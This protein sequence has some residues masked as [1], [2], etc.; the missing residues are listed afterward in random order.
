MNFL[1]IKFFKYSLVL[2]LIDLLVIWLWTINSDLGP[3]SA[4][5]VYIVVPFVFIINMII[6]A[7]LFFTK[8][9]YSPLFFINCIVASAITFSLFTL[10]MNNQDKEHFDSW[11]FSLQDTTFSITKWNKYNEFS[12]SYGENTGSSTSF[13]DGKCEQKKDT[14]FLITDSIRMYIHHDKLHNFRRSKNPITLK[15]RN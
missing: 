4:M 6:G 3:G 2:A 12:I 11:D 10:E 9:V 7:I 8:R 13:L 15:I 5:V 14:L 1:S